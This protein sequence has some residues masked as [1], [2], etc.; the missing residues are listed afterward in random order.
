[1]KNLL[2]IFLLLTTVLPMAGQ[3]DSAS[4]K[5]AFKNKIEIGILYSG[6]KGYRT[7][8]TTN[9]Q[10]ESGIKIRD[11]VENSIYIYSFGLS[12]NYSITKKIVLETGLLYAKKGFGEDI[13]FFNMVNNTIKKANYSFNYFY[14][15]VPI[16]IQYHFLIK[17]IHL[18]PSLG[19]SG[20]FLLEQENIQEIE[21]ELPN[22]TQIKN[23]SS[24]FNVSVIAGFGAK[25]PINNKFSVSLQPFYQYFLNQ[26]NKDNLTKDFIKQRLYTYGVSIGFYFSL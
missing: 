19:F 3:T 23:S 17:K 7:L 21:G 10:Y 18:Y 11:S 1:M 2:A 22:K 6:G 15:D 9:Q 14:L 20:S 26:T 8:S 12:L 24:L 5:A 13:T 25:Y 4:N 16:S